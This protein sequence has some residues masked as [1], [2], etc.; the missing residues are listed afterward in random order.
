MKRFILLMLVM[1]LL[2]GCAGKNT[3]TNELLSAHDISIIT[4]QAK[5][6]EVRSIVR[7]VYKSPTLDEFDSFIKD[8]EVS[9]DLLDELRDIFKLIDYTRIMGDVT[10]IEEGFYIDDT[11]GLIKFY[12]DI[13]MSDT[14]GSTRV[15]VFATVKDDILTS[16]RGYPVQ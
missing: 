3:G 11:R 14:Q 2:T 16:I 1:I 13:I 8:Y 4:V 10:V 5:Q 6:T 12:F 7:F 9:D 15:L